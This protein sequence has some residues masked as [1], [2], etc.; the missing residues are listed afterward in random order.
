MMRAVKHIDKEQNKPKATKP[1]KK[2]IKEQ[3]KEISSDRGKFK[4]RS[5]YQND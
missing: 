2:E 3:E 4:F 1:L 5:N